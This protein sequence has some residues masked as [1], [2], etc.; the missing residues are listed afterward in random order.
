MCASCPLRLEVTR[1]REV[2]VSIPLSVCF[3]FVCSSFVQVNAIRWA[4]APSSPIVESSSDGFK[5]I[6]A[7]VELKA[8]EHVVEVE[9]S[10]DVITVLL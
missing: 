10:D 2:F 4:Q 3:F 9:V 8:S 1:H 5:G 7:F 6:R